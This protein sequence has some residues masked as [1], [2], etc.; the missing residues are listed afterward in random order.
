MET[1][2]DFDATMTHATAQDVEAMRQKLYIE[3]EQTIL[4]LEAKLARAVALAAERLRIIEN[5]TDSIEAGVIT[6]TCTVC[7]GDGE[8]TEMSGNDPDSAKTVQCQYC[9]D[10]ENTFKTVKE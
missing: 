4:T 7:G 2:K 10:G 5:L 8:Y 1:T 3:S 6:V 9:T